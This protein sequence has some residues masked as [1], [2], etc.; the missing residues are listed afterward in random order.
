MVVLLVVAALLTRE[1]LFADRAYEASVAIMPFE[2]RTGDPSFD[3]LGTSLAEGVI[4]QLATVPEIRVLDLYTAASVVKDSLGTPR[5]HDTLS[6]EHIIHGY[7]ERRGD[8]LVVN[9]SESDVEGFLSLRTQ[10]LLTPE[11]LESDQVELANRVALTFLRDVGLEDR[12]APHRSVVGPGR[13][14]Y[15]AGTEALGQRTPAAMR[16]A[17]RWFREAIALEPTSAVALSAL[18]SAYALA[19][20]YKYDVGMSSYELAA[21]SYVAA[22]SA[23]ALDPQE[24]NGY[25][26]RGYVRALLGIE[27]D[28]AEADFRRAQELAPNAPN[29]PSWSARI[30]ARRDRVDDAFA[31]AARARDLDPL[32]AGRRTALASLGFQLGAY[33]VTIQESREAYRLEPRLSLAK[34]FE[35]RALALTGRAQECLRLDFEVYELVRALCLHAAG[36]EAEARELVR[37]AE[38]R[39]A[40]TGIDDPSYLP[41]LTAQDLAAYYGYVGDAENAG[42]WVEYAFEL[43]PAGVDERLLG[44]ALFDPVRDRPEYAA[45]L[46]AARE[47]A[48]ARFL[49]GRRSVESPL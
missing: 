8:T 25:A 48:R 27:I 10:H 35:G 18:S 1:R 7:I 17:I 28:E 43:S 23:I 32:Q 14:A 44:S 26:A 46:S 42:R 9:V 38:E 41:E 49:A 40:D 20:Y 34:A 29:A 15:L 45:A 2:N 21:R 37:A 4:T 19:V 5:L 47:E 13:D 12:Y 3:Y 22:D 6:V 39:L 31:E 36:R 11:R 24:A 16:E 30:L 33:D